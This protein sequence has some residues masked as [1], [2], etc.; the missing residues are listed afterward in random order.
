MNKLQTNIV[1]MIFLIITSVSESN[2]AIQQKKI[3]QK[4]ILNKQQQIDFIYNSANKCFNE[5]EVDNA[6]K[7][8]KNYDSLKI[9]L[10]S[11]ITDIQL[12]KI[13]KKYETDKKDNEIETI[14]TDKK[15]ISIEILKK[16]EVINKRNTLILIIFVAISVIAILGFFLLRMYREIRS[17]NKILI[18]Q[19]KQINKQKKEL[20]S[21]HTEIW[22]QKND[23]SEQSQLVMDQTR[24]ITF[25]NKEINDSLNYASMIQNALFMDL[26]DGTQILK[27]YF[28]VHKMHKNISGVFYW[29]SVKNNAGYFAVAE[30]SNKGV[31]GALLSILGMS[32]LNE[33]IIDKTDYSPAQMLNKLRNNF[34]RSLR[35]KT[36]T[37]RI[38]D[39]FN[40]AICKINDQ[41]KTI[42]YAGANIAVYYSSDETP[43]MKIEPDLM[44][45]GTSNKLGRE[46]A[47]K[48][49]DYKPGIK[50]YMLTAGSLETIKNNTVSDSFESFYNQYILNQPF[51]EQNQFLRN[52]FNNFSNESD[53]LIFGAEIE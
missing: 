11:L 28:F 34:L 31:A 10:D 9:I 45:I 52:E 48:F 20:E 22:K 38:S 17:A 53:V 43:L 44:P 19:T 3:T 4:D 16:Q 26:A 6:L 7:L 39:N 21:Q 36:Q 37:N 25:Q 27:N 49:I 29:T 5:G 32:L 46:F 41:N 18:F 23:L 51:S 24:I 14:K 40:L 13:E 42:E 12:E 33:L 2:C 1:V 30:P 8:I 15:L 50:L 35:R 47:N